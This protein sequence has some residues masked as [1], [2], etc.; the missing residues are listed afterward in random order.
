M[1]ELFT[2][3][4]QSAAAYRQLRVLTRPGMPAEHQSASAATCSHPQRQIPSH[5]QYYCYCCCCCCYYYYHYLLQ[6][7]NG[8]FPEQPG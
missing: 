2:G 8:V 3:A 1:S 7:F 6:P 5:N 4:D